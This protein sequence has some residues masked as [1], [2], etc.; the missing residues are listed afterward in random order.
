MVSSIQHADFGR[1]Y[2]YLSPTS[3]LAASST[4]SLSIIN[5]RFEALDL[6]SYLI[7]FDALQ[8]FGGE[9]LVLGV[10]RRNFISPMFCWRTWFI[11]LLSNPRT[12]WLFLESNIGVY[13]LLDRVGSLQFGCGDR[14]YSWCRGFGGTLI[15]P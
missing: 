11:V 2:K 5:T 4:H 15:R 1:A 6:L 8:E 12:L 14:L 13:G 3:N 9:D 7:K 10:D